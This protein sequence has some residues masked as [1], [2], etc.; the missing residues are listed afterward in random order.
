MIIQNVSQIL[1][2]L[3]KAESGSDFHKSPELVP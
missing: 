1:I 3:I 2:I